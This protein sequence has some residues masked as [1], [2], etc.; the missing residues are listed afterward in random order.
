MF[1]ISANTGKEVREVDI[2]QSNPRFITFNKK[3]GDFYITGHG[4]EKSITMVEKYA[5]GTDQ[6]K[7]DLFKED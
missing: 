6:I 2:R 4:N 7:E 5:F 3:N 1:Q